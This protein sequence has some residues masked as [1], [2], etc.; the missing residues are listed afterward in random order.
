[1]ADCYSKQ[2]RSAVMSRIKSKNTLPE[3]KLRRA[4]WSKG[5]RFRLNSN[6]VG[7]PDLAFPKQKIVVFIDG[8]FWHKCPICYKQPKSNKK[9]W[10]SKIE[11]NVARD[12]K[13]NRILE[14]QGWIILRFWEHNIKNSMSQ[15]IR[16]IEQNKK[17]KT[18]VH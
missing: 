5:Y 13:V 18:P 10:L 11:K 6:I 2:T 15:I 12:K 4:L 8:C 1:M 16:T 9:Y 7:K 14:N 17:W 3:L